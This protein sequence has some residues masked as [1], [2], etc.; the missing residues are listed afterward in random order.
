MKAQGKEEDKNLQLKHRFDKNP[1]IRRKSTAKTQFTQRGRWKLISSE[2]EGVVQRKTMRDEEKDS[3][4]DEDDE[5][6]A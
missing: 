6:D 1:Q 5:D 3:E 2:E 4:D